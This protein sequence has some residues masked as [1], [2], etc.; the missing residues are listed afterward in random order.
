MYLIITEDGDIEIKPVP[1]KDFGEYEEVDIP[2]FVDYIQWY[3]GGE[4]EELSIPYFPEKIKNVKMLAGKKKASKINMVASYIFGTGFHGSPLYGNVAVV[5]E[6]LD[7]ETNEHRL[8]PM[9]TEQIRVLLN[10][11]KNVHDFYFPDYDEYDIWE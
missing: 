3:I 5:Y 11:L 2:K 6:P 7:K 1:T 8:K 10:G 4:F 9:D